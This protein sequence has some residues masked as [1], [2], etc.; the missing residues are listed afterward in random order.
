MSENK[1]TLEELELEIKL[2][3]TI[4]KERITNKSIFANKQVEVLVYGLIGLILVAFVGAV[5]KLVFI[6]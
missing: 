1:P 2:R 5:L 6:K 4:E 3:D